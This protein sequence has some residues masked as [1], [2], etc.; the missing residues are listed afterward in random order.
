MENNIIQYIDEKISSD[1][2]IG[3]EIIYNYALWLEPISYTNYKEHAI[4][5][6]KFKSLFKNVINRSLKIK[7][8]AKSDEINNKFNDFIEFEISFGKD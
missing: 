4:K 8:N 2:L 5:D 3:V 7:Y 6:N 1:D